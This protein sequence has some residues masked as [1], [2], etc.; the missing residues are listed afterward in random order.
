[1]VYHSSQ[2]ARSSNKM[3]LLITEDAAVETG[4][5]TAVVAR[6]VGCTIA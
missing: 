2:N 3:V 6:V 4:W 5:T 1:M